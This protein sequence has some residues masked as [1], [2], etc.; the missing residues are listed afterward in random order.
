M[1]IQIDRERCTGCAACKNICPGNLIAA[2]EDRRAYL[3]RPQDCWGCAACL[4]E[5]PAGAIRLELDPELGGRGEAL[6]AHREG[7][8]CV[9]R[10][11]KGKEMIRTLVTD[12][13][14]ANEY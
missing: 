10:I 8:R 2:G 14:K 5:C 1:S 9:W 6:T 11:S 7:T 12:S 3:R 4:K 13:G